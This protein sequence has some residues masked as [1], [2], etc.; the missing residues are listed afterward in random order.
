M[1]THPYQVKKTRNPQVLSGMLAINIHVR[2]LNDR[3]ELLDKILFMAHKPL[4]GA[5]SNGTMSRH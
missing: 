1:D 4:D 2:V 3:V 5:R